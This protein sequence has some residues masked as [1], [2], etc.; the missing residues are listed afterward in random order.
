M[1][2][3]AETCK[4]TTSE[5]AFVLAGGVRQEPVWSKWS[6]LRQKSR[7]NKE[8]WST[9]V[10]GWKMT[11]VEQ[12]ETC[13]RAV[14]L[15]PDYRLSSSS[16]W[17]PSTRPQLPT[18]KNSFNYVTYP[19]RKSQN[20]IRWQAFM[21]IKPR[22]TEGK[23]TWSDGDKSEKQKFKF[24]IGEQRTQDWREETDKLTK[25]ERLK[26]TK[27]WRLI[28]DRCN[29]WGKNSRKRHKDR[30]WNAQHDTWA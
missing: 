10:T 23:K 17:H 21:L 26:H 18:R 22:Q 5:S 14:L 25:R 7:G 24:R 3:V 2:R 16:D 15:P 27:K 29:R 8:L 28:R 11:M 30:K 6:C 12:R 1:P 4:P 19:P 9:F 20:L 13:F